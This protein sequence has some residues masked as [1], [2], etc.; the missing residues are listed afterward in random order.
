MQDTEALMNAH[1]RSAATPKRPKRAGTAQRLGT[2]KITREQTRCNLKRERGIEHGT[3]QHTHHYKFPFLLG[4]PAELRLARYLLN[5]G[6][7][8]L[9]LTEVMYSLSCAKRQHEGTNRGCA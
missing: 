6:F 4:Q 9:S 5:H 8:W 1:T 7:W 3:L 2:G